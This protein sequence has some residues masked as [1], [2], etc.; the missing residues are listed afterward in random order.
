MI[1][2]TSDSVIFP[3][4][5]TRTS[6]RLLVLLMLC[7]LLL[8]LPVTAHK[9][10]IFAWTEGDI[11]HGET[12][13][14]GKR[15]P[16]NAEVTVLDNKSRAVLLTTT[17]DEQGR[18]SFKLPEQAV[19]E[20]MDLLLVVNSGEGHRGEW[21]MPAAEYLPATEEET[22]SPVQAT[23]P[24]QG[25]E[26]SIAVSVPQVEP[27]AVVGLDEQVLRRIVASELDKQLNEKL[28]PIKQMLAENSEEQPDF[29]DILGGIGYI[30][31]LAGLLAWFQ[32]KRRGGSAQ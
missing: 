21:P 9:L 14:S 17:T 2:F 4:F 31:G 3:R 19:R 1:T 29:R 13:F 12:A 15:K 27:V 32:S 11:M 6:L 16:R 24:D 30:I 7:S 23:E 18:F 8:P 10:R 26:Q 25:P 22:T 5:L 20:Q 28:A